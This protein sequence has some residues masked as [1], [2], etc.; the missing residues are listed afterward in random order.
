LWER[1][2]FSLDLRELSVNLI[3]R[4]VVINEAAWS[5]KQHTLKVAGAALAC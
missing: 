2:S 5:S 4:G 3:F 1:W